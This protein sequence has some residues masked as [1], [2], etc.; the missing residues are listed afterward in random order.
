MK[1]IKTVVHVHTNCSFDSNTSP[2]DLIATARAAGVG[3]I[4]VTDHDEIAGAVAARELG[5]GVRIIVGEEIT[6][7][8]GHVIGLFLEERIPPGLT[9]EE[10]AQ[11]IRAQGGLVLAAHPFATLCQH[12][13]NHAA[14][15]RLLP[16]LDAVEVC[17]A[18]NL[19]WWESGWA[20]RYAAKHGLT[21]FVGDDAHIRGHLAACHQ[22]MP[23]FD[24]PADFLSALRQAELHTGWFAPD[25]YLAMGLQHTWIN[26]LGM[27]LA[28]FG[29]NAPGG[30]AARAD[31]QPTTKPAFALATGSES[32]PGG[33]KRA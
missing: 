30:Q 7:T 27:S 6:T 17:N 9:P 11:R 26:L 19:L 3:C 28:G 21:P 18:Q 14:M 24:G 5:G 31:E 32:T 8:E 12:S 2:E 23:A 4:A 10:T 20:R 13:L 1:K 15:E 33:E 22:I 25:Y 16:W 29:V